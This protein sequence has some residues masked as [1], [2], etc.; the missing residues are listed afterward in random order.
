MGNAMRFLLAEDVIG[1]PPQIHASLEGGD[2]QLLRP[3]ENCR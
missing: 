3:A 2:R 1:Q